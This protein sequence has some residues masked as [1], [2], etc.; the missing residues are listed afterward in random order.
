MLVMDPCNAA[1]TRAYAG[2]EGIVQR[3]VYDGT[4]NNSV[5]TRTSGCLIL[6]PQRPAQVKSDADT[7][8][9]TF[10]VLYDGNAPGYSFLTTNGAKLRALAACIQVYAAGAAFSTITGEWAAGVVS[11]DTLAQGSTISVDTLFQ[12]SSV[13]GVINKEGFE[14]KWQPGTLD[15]TYTTTS[16]TV[17]GDNNVVFVAYRGYPAGVG[18]TFRY[19]TVLEWT[20]KIGIGIPTTAVTTSGVN[21]EQQLAALSRVA[22]GWWHKTASDILEDMSRA[23]RYVARQGLAAASQVAV[24]RINQTF[25]ALMV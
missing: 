14:V 6:A 2:E 17:D 8:S 15:N 21:H 5:A 3:F 12:I 1:P 11:C 19:T 18:L 10:P 4:I 7:S 13:R 24:S 23:G 22:P 9:A 16:G 25:G 20:P